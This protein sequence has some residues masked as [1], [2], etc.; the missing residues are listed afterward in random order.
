MKKENGIRKRLR[1]QMVLAV[2]GAGVL[3]GISGCSAMGGKSPY[4][5]VEQYL[6]NRYGGKFEIEE[7]AENGTPVY[8]QV[9]QK[10]GEKLEFEVFPVGEEYTNK[11][12]DDTCPVAFVMK[13]A[14]DMGLVLEPGTEEKELVA[15]VDGYGEIEELADKLAQIAKAY[16][17]AGLPARF[18]TGTVGDGW[19]SANIRVEIRGFSPEGYH[20]GVIRIPDSVTGFHDKES[21]EQYLE[22]NYLIYLDRYYAGEIPADVPEEAFEAVRKEEKGLTVFSGERATEYPYLERNQL[23]FG[24]AYRLACEEGWEPQ[25]GENSF[26]LAKGEESYQFE[27]VFEENEDLSKEREEFRYSGDW[28]PRGHAIDKKPAVYWRQ[29]GTEERTLAAPEPSASE[30]SISAEILEQI[31]GT[32]IEYGLELQAA[33]ERIQEIQKEAKEYLLRSDRKQQG[34]SV[35]I[36]DWRIA[37]SGMEQARRLETD[38]MYFEADEDM[39]FLRFHLDVENLGSEKEVFIRPVAAYEDLLTY[40]VT[41]GGHRYI[42][43]NLVGMTDMTSIAIEPREVAS[44]GLIFHVRESV[45]QEDEHIFLVFMANGESRVFQIR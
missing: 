13:K 22:Q 44:S 43:V 23:Y 33:Q 28:T 30:G 27:L 6:K 15:T 8:Y 4:P 29:V 1:N 10:D 20:P 31:T 7:V 2:I 38:I 26:T 36:A 25:A 45:L 42:P 35:E 32:E 21:M 40:L 16:E 37:L 12:F 11:G 41:S 17:E 34:E 19:N 39:T 18:T 5:E 3:L 24:Q 9:V 14:E